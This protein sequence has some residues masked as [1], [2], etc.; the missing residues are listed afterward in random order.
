MLKNSIGRLIPEELEGYGKVKPFAGAYATVPEGNKAP[1]KIPCH[2]ASE[3]DKLLPSI[4]E[5]LKRAGIRDGMTLSFH[6]HMRDG[7]LV[8]EQVFDV[9]RKLGIRDLRLAPSAVFPCQK[10]LC[11]D[12]ERGI[13][14][15]ISGGIDGIVGR[16]ISAGKLREPF[17][18]RSHGGRVRAIEAGDEPVDIAI[19]AA[20][21]ADA[22]GNINGTGGPSACGALGYPMVDAEYAKTVI[23]VTDNLVDFPAAPISIPHSKVDWVVK[24]DKIGIPEK[25]VS[26]TLKITR[27]PIRLRIAETAAQVIEHSGFF[28]NGFSFQAGA[29]GTSLAAAAYVREKM[30]RNGITGSFGSGGITG[31]FVDMLE[32]GLFRTLLDTQSFDLKAVA[33]LARNPGHLEMSAGHYANLHTK[34]CVASMLDFVVLGAT[35]I[36]TDFN[37]NVTSEADGVM[38]HGIGGHQ[39]TAAGAKVSII[40]TPL[41]RGRIPMIVDRVNLVSSPGETIDVIVTERGI[42]VNPLKK[43]LTENLRKGG[44]PI[45][46]IRDLKKMAENISGKPAPVQMGEKIVGLVEYRDGTILD[47][48]YQKNS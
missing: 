44:L 36:D 35:E 28:Q 5:A 17:V 43:E 18:A 37:V 31:Y 12:I 42:A 48:I 13:V 8:M 30:K 33:S 4:E 10:F 25:I 14:R 29:G 3:S 39:D 1:V 41:L 2:R 26:G 15:R 16:A 11:E 40:V 22:A 34:G 24:I 27:D 21:T 20:P 23:A 45:V 19:I 46:D 9:I 38:L 32:E 47:V 7:D 6:H